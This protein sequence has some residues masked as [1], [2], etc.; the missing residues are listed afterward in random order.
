MRNNKWGQDFGT[1]EQCVTKDGLSGDTI[2]WHA[3]WEWRGGEANVKSYPNTK[4]QISN[5]SLVSD[6]D[7]MPTKANWSYIYAGPTLRA[8]V[9]YDFFTAAD[10]EHNTWSG[11]YE[12]MIW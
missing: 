9:S 12:I 2:S 11:D 10:P 6:I 5:K 7:T 4:L 8:G 1:G 3:N